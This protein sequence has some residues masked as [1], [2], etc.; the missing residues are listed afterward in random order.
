M[1]LS[2]RYAR[3][4]GLLYLLLVP[5]A[6]FDLMY[7]PGKL[8]VKNNPAETAANLLTHEML[9]RVD[10]V[11]GLLSSVVFALVAIGLYRMLK[12]VQPGHALTMLIIVLISITQSFVGHLLWTG[13]LELSRGAD[14]LAAIDQ[15]QR[16]AIAMLCLQI[17]TLGTY[18]SE[19]FWGLWLLPLGMLVYRS[20]FLPRFIGIWLLLN[21][22]AYV[23]ISLTGLLAP[24]YAGT[25]FS[26]ATPALFGELAL[27]LWLL[28]AGVR[29]PVERTVPGKADT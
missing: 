11:V 9:L 29:M 17:N 18:Y 2:K 23:L 6:V 10:L 7:V 21:G 25:F 15:T 3:T 5:A 12:S 20:G 13:A 24:D 22:S 26:I 14:F 28:I 4:I 8:I 16:H 19:M 1:V 27:T